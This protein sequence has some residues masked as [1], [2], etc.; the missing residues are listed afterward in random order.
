M[1]MF[2]SK[3][4][5]PEKITEFIIQKK[6]A[7]QFISGCRY[8]VP[9]MHN[10][11]GEMD[12]FIVRRSGYSEEFEIKISKA[13]FRADNKKAK[14]HAFYNKA[15]TGGDLFIQYYGTKAKKNIPNRFSYVVPESLDI[16][17]EDVPEYAGLCELRGRYLYYLKRP[18]LMHKE[19]LNWSEKIATSL[20]WRY[21][22]VIGILKG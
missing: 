11:F 17:P 12:F 7:I 8:V 18:P 14:K 10:F 3:K 2:L 15:F 16:K 1:A 5:E 6:L 4:Q 9:N 19:K 22:K 13:D 20:S 21:L